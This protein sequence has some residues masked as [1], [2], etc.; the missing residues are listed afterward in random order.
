[1]AFWDRLLKKSEDLQARCIEQTKLGVELFEMDRSQDAL[2][3]FDRAVKISPRVAEIHLRRG[4]CLQRLDRPAEAERAFRKAVQL[5]PGAA[6]ATALFR[7]GEM[8]AKLGRFKEGL[9]CFNHVLDHQPDLVPAMQARAALLEQ[10][11]RHDEAARVRM[12]LRS[13]HAAKP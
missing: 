2:E 13:Q 10:I 1:M 5:K 9:A 8:L 4:M 6:S 7:R 12:T 3:A 11:G